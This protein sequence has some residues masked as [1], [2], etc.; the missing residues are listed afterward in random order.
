MH[1]G[2]GKGLESLIPNIAEKQYKSSEQ[3]MRIPVDK[4]KP[5]TY[6]PRMSFNQERL[7]ELAESIKKHGLAQPILVTPSA[8][9][10]EY[11]LIAGERRLR[12]AKMANL[13]LVPSMVRKTNEKEKFQLSLVENL[14][15]DD[16]NPIEE[17]EA[18]ARII[19]EFDITQAQVSDMLGIG[20][21]KIANTLR[22]LNL[23]DYIQDAIREGALSPGHARNLVG[24]EDPLKQKELARRIIKEKLTTRDVEEIVQNWKTA[25]SAPSHKKKHTKSPEVIEIE[26]QLQ[27]ILGTKIMIKYRN[28]KGW[29]NIAFYSL[30]HFDSI[31]STLKSKFKN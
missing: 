15:R 28:N 3:L 16:L 1:R 31:V 13:K 5:N 19:K 10:G 25:R 6:Q 8:V 14:Q 20:R 17:A 4:I 2:L 11:E 12:A 21:S 22:L 9:P 27:H 23:P 7:A 18:Y 29:I 26:N 30:D 24:I